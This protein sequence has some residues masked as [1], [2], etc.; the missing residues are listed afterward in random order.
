MRRA[1]RVRSMNGLCFFLAWRQD[2]T[3]GIHQSIS[4]GRPN[5]CSWV[6]CDYW[7]LFLFKKFQLLWLLFSLTGR[8][9]GNFFQKQ[10]WKIT[11]QTDVL[12]WFIKHNPVYTHTH[13]LCG[14]LLGDCG[15]LSVFVGVSVSSLCSHTWSKCH[16]YARR[17]QSCFLK[18]CFLI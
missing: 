6:V 10:I 15:C 3:W 8:V 2:L 18:W 7:E 9:T 11:L 13:T 12:W 17:P 1:Y 4:T 14:C 5:F 16:K